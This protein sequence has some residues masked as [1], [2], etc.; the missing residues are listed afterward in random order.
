MSI[1]AI[2]VLIPIDHKVVA[3]SDTSVCPSPPCFS[4]GQGRNP[5]AG[6]GAAAYKRRAVV[7]G[8]YERVME[9]EK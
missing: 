8:D 3:L 5:A 9:I 2:H 7:A 1:E 6:G 4:E